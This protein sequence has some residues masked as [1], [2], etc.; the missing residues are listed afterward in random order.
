MNHTRRKISVSLV[1]VALFC[2]LSCHAAPEIPVPQGV[3]MEEDVVFGTSALG[4]G[5]RLDRVMNVYQPLDAPSA[6]RPALVFLHGN[7]GD[8]PYPGDRQKRYREYVDYFTPKGYVCFVPSWDLRQGAAEGFEIIR[9][10]MVHIRSK[11]ADYGIDP[12]RVGVVGH[13]YGSR[14]ACTLG[15]ANFLAPEARANVVVMLAGGMSYPDDCDEND[16]PLLLV[17]G[18]ADSWFAQAPG[19]VE[20][21][22]R[23][24]APH[25]YIEVPGGEHSIPIDTPVAFGQSLL[26][27]VESFL[28]IHLK[29]AKDSALQFIATRHRGPGRVQLG[30]GASYGLYPQGH[31]VTA[32]AIPDNGA[33]FKG[34]VSPTDGVGSSFT[35]TVQKAETVVA[36][37]SAP[38]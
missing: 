9:M 31:A 8:K 1:V 26:T 28:D 27:V 18:N 6:P 3:H 4:D 38:Q 17:Y 25:A 12:A 2:M 10:A 19:I 33:A 23:G 11:A 29:D 15:T 37:F 30:T 22:Q 5:T 13:S 35:L 24:N 34:W 21:L 20:S 32:T 36:E 16:A 7:P 14:H